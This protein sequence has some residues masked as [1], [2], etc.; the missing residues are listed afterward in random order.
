MSTLKALGIT[1][2]INLEKSRKVVAKRTFEAHDL[3]TI[4]RRG[5]EK[6]NR[7]S[8]APL[9]HGDV[10]T[11][12]GARSTELGKSPDDNATKSIY[13]YETNCLSA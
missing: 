2:Q 10:I 12:G 7:V 4:Q 5:Q 3:M 13:T 1:A 11:L 9:N 8:N 6:P